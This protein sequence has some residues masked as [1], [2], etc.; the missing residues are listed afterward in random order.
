MIAAGELGDLTSGLL[1][2]G[3]GRLG[4]VGTYT[5]DAR[6]LTSRQVKAVSGHLDLSGKPDC[7]R[8]RHL[9]ELW[10]ECDNCI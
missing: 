5:I 6:M 10:D 1:L 2:W 9:S 8:Y 4:N 3:A 7:R